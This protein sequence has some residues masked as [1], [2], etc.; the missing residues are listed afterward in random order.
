M[1]LRGPTPVAGWPTRLGAL[2]GQADTVTI[3]GFADGEAA[4]PTGAWH[5]RLELHCLASDSPFPAEPDHPQQI[6]SLDAPLRLRHGEAEQSLPRLQTG[7]LAAPGQLAVDQA[8]RLACL[9]VR[10]GTDATLIARP[11]QGPMLLLADA[12]WLAWLLA[13]R[14]DVQQGNQRWPLDSA[15]PV[16][17]PHDP[18]QRLRI[19]GGGELLL[20]RLAA[21]PTAGVTPH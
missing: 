2:P 8:T 20:V 1:S 15:S 5:W 7:R 16:W 21:P 6:A 19:D 10:D 14:A 3:A 13:G 9:A 4:D 11:L 18:A 12:R 17:L